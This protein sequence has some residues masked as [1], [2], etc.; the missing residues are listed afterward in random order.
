[1]QTGDRHVELGFLG[2]LQLKEFSGLAF[3]FQRYQAL[4]T[5][6]TVV[7]MYHRRTFAQLG[8]VLDDVFASVAAFLATPTLH[9]ALAEQW[10][11]GDQR[12]GW[13]L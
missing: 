4:V 2:I 11:F 9:D 3:D 7:D 1:M 12:Q 6:D 13:V 5:A 10:A 8:E